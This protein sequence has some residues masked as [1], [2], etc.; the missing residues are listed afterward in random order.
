MNANNFASALN[1]NACSMLTEGRS[2]DQ[3]PLVLISDRHALT[4]NHTN[5]GVS[6]KVVYKRDDGSYQT[7]TTI[8]SS[9]VGIWD[10]RVLCFNEAI[11][12]VTPY[13]LPPSDW[14]ERYAPSAINAPAPYIPICA[15]PV[16]IKGMHD[17]SG[18]GCSFVGAFNLSGARVVGNVNPVASPLPA[19][20]AALTDWTPPAFIGGDS[21]SPIFLPVNGELVLVGV[22]AQAGGAYSPTYA[23]VGATLQTL[24]TAQAGTAYAPVYADFSGFNVY[25]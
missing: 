24:M 15:T 5:L 20:H 4:A 16:L 23:G 9:Q 12:G 21:G 25:P 10:L 14:V 17:L 3:F 2:A 1:W 6:K 18:A 7:V 13:K 11:T 8:A 22:I 19:Q